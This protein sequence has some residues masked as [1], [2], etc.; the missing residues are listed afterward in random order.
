MAAIP[1]I[2]NPLVERLDVGVGSSLMT[3]SRSR[4]SNFI[5]IRAEV[6]SGCAV[7]HPTAA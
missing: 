4:I 5:A 1:R 6:D 2:G 3:P 7:I